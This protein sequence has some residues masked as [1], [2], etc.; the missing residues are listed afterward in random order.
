MEII[1]CPNCNKLTGYKRSLGFGT[2]FAVVLTAG[3]W[4]LVVPFYPKRCI[5]CGLGKSET[6]P[7]T[8]TWRAPALAC[9][10]VVLLALLYGYVGD[11]FSHGRHGFSKDTIEQMRAD[12]VPYGNWYHT[13]QLGEMKQAERRVFGS[14]AAE[15][16]QYMTGSG[17]WAGADL[18][19]IKFCKPHD[20]GDHGG[21]ISVDVATGRAAGELRS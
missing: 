4:L 18:A 1:F 14:R 6:V 17:Q 20:C 21:V 10:A 19:V 5:T 16:E 15:I 9:L 11:R 12:L 3:F 13:M 8:Q 7:W 2:F